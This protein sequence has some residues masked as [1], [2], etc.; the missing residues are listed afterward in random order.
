[1]EDALSHS[2]RAPANA[3]SLGPCLVVTGR[4]PVL[5]DIRVTR[6]GIHAVPGLVVTKASVTKA[7]NIS[8]EATRATRREPI[9]LEP[10]HG[11][12]LSLTWVELRAR[13]DGA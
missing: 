4:A 6:C 10:A 5:P 8:P 1:M 2:R 11:Y 13:V 7:V 9:N 3:D 12:S